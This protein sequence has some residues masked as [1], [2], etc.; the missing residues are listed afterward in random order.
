MVR[1]LLAILAICVTISLFLLGRRRKRISYF[2][3]ETQVIGLHEKLP[4]SRVQILFDGTAVTEVRL[5]VVAVTNSGNEPI[6]VE[7]F[8][9][10]LR[11]S[12][13]EPTKILSAKL[14]EVN[15]G[16]LQPTI[17]AGVN[18]IV[19]NP[20]LLNP[21][22]WLRIAALINQVGILSV[23]ARVVGVKRITKAVAGGGIK[24]DKMVQR[25][26]LIV[27]IGILTILFILAGQ[28]FRL[29]VPNGVAEQRVIKVFLIAVLLILYD[30]LKISVLDLI[31]HFKNKQSSK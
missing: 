24:S 8:E 20:L 27:L 28:A 17:K 5:V 9:R 14:S 3:S 29:W 2:L 22:D 6:R 23:D 13:P 11:F 4:P 15:P 25:L 10:P 30:G 19:V 18:E 1:T 26:A 31:S 16:N 7:D 12:W 21:G